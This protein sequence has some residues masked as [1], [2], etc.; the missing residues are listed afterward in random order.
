MARAR[1]SRE[2]SVFPDPGHDHARC[3]TDAMAVAE[4]RC[5]ERGQRL[6]PIRRDVLAT[7]LVSHRPLGAYEI[8]E[9]LAPTGPR[10]GPITN[11]R[12]LPFPRGAAPA[13]PAGSTTSFQTRSTPH[14]YRP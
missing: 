1:P 6:T 5:V 10:P 11:N 8:M 13:P 3:S 2:H 4:A 7:L 14:A 9:R 12:T